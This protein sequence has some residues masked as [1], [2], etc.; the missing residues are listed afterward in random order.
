MA[1]QRDVGR[2]DVSADLI[3]TGF[4][5]PFENVAQLAPGQILRI[6]ADAQVLRFDLDQLLQPAARDVLDECRG[7]LSTS[8]GLKVLAVSSNARDATFYELEPVEHRLDRL[9]PA[10]LV[11]AIRAAR[12]RRLVWSDP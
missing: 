4:N 11:D 10:E 8:P 12:G 9:S 2:V 5:H 1:E 7:L 6:E 3:D